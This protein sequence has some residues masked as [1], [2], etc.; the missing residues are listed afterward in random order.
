M[1]ATPVVRTLD[2]SVGFYGQN[3]PHPGYATHSAVLFSTALI[4]AVSALLYH[5]FSRKNWLY[6][7]PHTVHIGHTRLGSGR[8]PPRQLV[9]V[10]P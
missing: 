2:T 9:L 1:T 6:D 10:T 3:L 4:A 8:H 5:V 7:T